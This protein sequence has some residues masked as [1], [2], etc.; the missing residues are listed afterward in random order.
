M[1]TEKWAVMKARNGATAAE[2]VEAACEGALSRPLGHTE[3]E[4]RTESASPPRPS[5]P[6]TSPR[7][8]RRH[9]DEHDSDDSCFSC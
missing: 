5:A 6:P 1:V 7:K 4:M 9:R 2:V 8:Q 3:H